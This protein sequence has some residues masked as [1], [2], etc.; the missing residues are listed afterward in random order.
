MR[1]NVRRTVRA[2]GTHRPDV[3]HFFADG[4]EA[5]S[6]T[7]VGPTGEDGRTIEMGGEGEESMSGGKVVPVAFM[8]AASERRREDEDHRGASWSTEET[9]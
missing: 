3:N 1:K 8:K 7:G 5:S 4:E 2:H 9:P 6:A